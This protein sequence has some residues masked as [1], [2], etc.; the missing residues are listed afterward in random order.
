MK[1]PHEF[2]TC[3]ASLY[4]SPAHSIT[5]NWPHVSLSASNPRHSTSASE[6]VLGPLGKVSPVPFGSVHA[7]SG[8]V[9]QC[10]Q[11]LRWR[12]PLKCFFLCGFYWNQES[13]LIVVL[14]SPLCTHSPEVWTVA[15]AEEMSFSS[16][17]QMRFEKLAQCMWSPL[18]AWK[19]TSCFPP[20]ST[21]ELLRGK[22]KSHQMRGNLSGLPKDP[23]LQAS[24]HSQWVLRRPAE[25]R[26]QVFT[27]PPCLF[28]FVL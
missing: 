15:G 14:T 25:R 3:T 9:R 24:F 18:F 19:R 13:L 20:E 22:K 5:R 8:S 11:A 10:S 4:V 23:S 7:G 12:K 26:S 28:Q 16:F 1:Q 6:P 2:Q 27:F 17:V 21:K